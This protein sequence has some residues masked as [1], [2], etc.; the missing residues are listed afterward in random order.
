M[1]ELFIY[2]RIKAVGASS[3]LRTVGE[4]QARLR[5]RHRG[6][7]A[8]LLRRPDE[9]NGTQTWMEIYSFDAHPGGIT[10]EIE[11]EIEHEAQALAAFI[12]GSRHTEVFIPCAL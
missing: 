9:H 11:A 12:D 7:T 5:S 2:Y 4:C 3:A 8:R 1:R 10:P 6:L